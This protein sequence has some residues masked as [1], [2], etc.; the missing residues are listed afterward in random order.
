MKVA[1]LYAIVFGA[2]SVAASTSQHL[3]GEHFVQHGS[4][5]RPKT[6]ST[7]ENSSAKKK[8]PTHHHHHDKHDH[9]K[10]S[11]PAHAQHLLKREPPASAVA[12]VGE[13]LAGVF[14]SFASAGERAGGERAANGLAGAGHYSPAGTYGHYPPP[15]AYAHPNAY[16]PDTA[17]TAHLERFGRKLDKLKDGQK[18]NTEQIDLMQKL[19]AKQLE[20]AQGSAA[21]AP[22]VKRG[23][24][25]GKLLMMGAGGVL[26]GYGA[27][28]FFDTKPSDSQTGYSKGDTAAIQGAGG[29]AP[30][31]APVDGAPGGGQGGQG[32]D[33]GF[34]GPYQIQ[35]SNLV[36]V[37]DRQN[38]VHVLDPAQQY[39]EVPPPPGWSPPGSAGGGRADGGGRAAG[40]AAAGGG[41]R[42][43]G[44]GASAGNGADS[45]PGFDG[46][47]QIQGSNLVYVIDRQNTV[48]VLDPAQQY[49]GGAATSWLVSAWFCW[50]WWC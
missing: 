46:P 26:L 45:D 35:G 19:Q 12:E 36:Y 34:D 42:G 9:K 3:A 1:L 20:G 4:G 17:T 22:V 21:A 32:S 28:K 10:A 33:P 16:A 2:I 47:Y 40:G 25:I 37:I 43:A 29:A 24:G 50:W 38:T 39:R 48:H 27:T 14:K 49:R 18:A 11:K 6:S 13:N 15:H 41:A 5:H 8:G 30:G 7:K 31:Q 23:P 44:S